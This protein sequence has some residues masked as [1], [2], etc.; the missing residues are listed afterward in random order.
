M[1][2]KDHKDLN[3]SRRR[4][5]K[6]AAATGAVALAGVAVVKEKKEN[7]ENYDTHPISEKELEIVFE[8]SFPNQKPNRLFSLLTRKPHNKT[9]DRYESFK[10]EVLS[11]GI[12][13][14]TKY[15][16]A[17]TEF[18][19]FYGDD[20]DMPDKQ[21]LDAMYNLIKKETTSL[22][23]RRFAPVRRTNVFVSEFDNRPSMTLKRDIK[24]KGADS[25]V[26]TSIYSR[27]E[28]DGFWTEFAQNL[29]LA[30]TAVENLTQNQ[31]PLANAIGIAAYHAQNGLSFAEYIRTEDEVFL[32]G[33]K[34]NI[35]RLS[36]TRYNELKVIL[37]SESEELAK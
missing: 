37:T 16:R 12:N 24:G 28:N 3:Q 17:G 30:G 18:N 35:P 33:E 31:E 11:A 15:K 14:H 32:F 34:I 36:E 6:A 29:L 22:L 8:D 27:D 5:L 10:E 7:A 9:V 20:F 1:S 26:N 4:F 19:F 2:E 21:T 23:N 13:T 25:L